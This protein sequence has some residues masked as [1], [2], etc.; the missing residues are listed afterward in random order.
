MTFV[1]LCV[2]AILVGCSSPPPAPGTRSHY[3]GDRLDV[4]APVFRGINSKMISVTVDGDVVHPGKYSL[5]A[6]SGISD[7]IRQAGGFTEFGHQ[8]AVRLDRGG[9]LESWRK[10]FCYRHAPG[11]K[12]LEMRRAP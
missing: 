6:L 5:P 8:R 11:E 2:A 10:E 4:G 7:A 12:G 9:G 3:G 1:V